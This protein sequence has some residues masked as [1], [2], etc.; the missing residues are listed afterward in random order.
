M[1]KWSKNV[2]VIVIEISSLLGSLSPDSLLH[3]PAAA[4]RSGHV[5]LH[6]P[7]WPRCCLEHT[8]NTQWTKFRRDAP[9]GLCV[10]AGLYRDIR[11]EGPPRFSLPLLAARWS[12]PSKV[13]RRRVQ[14]TPNLEPYTN[15]PQKEHFVKEQGQ[16][17]R[18]PRWNGLGWTPFPLWTSAYQTAAAS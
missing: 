10:H 6:S 12:V 17:D 3:V 13:L 8:G 5:T 2:P 15:S 18:A 16:T 11:W 9:A 14:Q 4:C 1:K 7:R